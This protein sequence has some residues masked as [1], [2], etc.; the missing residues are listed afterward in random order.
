MVGSRTSYM[1]LVQYNN[2][3]H[4][5]TREEERAEKEM[6]AMLVVESGGKRNSNGSVWW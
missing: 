2:A 6:A 4:R 3:M 1:P 5:S